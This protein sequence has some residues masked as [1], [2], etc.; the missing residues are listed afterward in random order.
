MELEDD[1]E[2]SAEELDFL[3]QDAIRKINQRKLSSA[4]ASTSGTPGPPIL[5]PN[6]IRGELLVRSV[7]DCNGPSIELGEK[8][9][10]SITDWVLPGNTVG[11]RVSC[12]F[13]FFSTRLTILLLK[14]RL[15]HFLLQT[16]EDG[17]NQE[18][19]VKYPLI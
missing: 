3:E 18:K 16:Q 10:P 1:W 7:V 19:Q 13:I 8:K 12:R 2:P 5:Q 14:F 11:L 4:V 15:E 6:Q 17:I 9:P